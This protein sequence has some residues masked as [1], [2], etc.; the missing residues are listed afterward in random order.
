MSATAASPEIIENARISTWFRVGGSADRFARPRGLDEL[1]RCIE[2]DRDLRVVGD[3]ANLLVGDDGVGELVVALDAPELSQIEI[4]SLSGRVEVGAGAPLPKVISAT[5]KAG[6]GGLERIAGIPASIGGAIA[7]NAGGSFGAISDTLESVR[8]IDRNG[9]IRERRASE[10]NLDYRRADLHGEIVVSAVFQ[11][12]P[13]DAEALHDRLVEVMGYKKRTQPLS[14]RSAG[15]AFRNPVL[16]LDLEDIGQAGERV[17]AGLLIDRAGCKGLRVGGA[18][19]SSRHA[20]FITTDP[21]AKA[22]D[23]VGVMVEVAGR[24]NDYAGVR[25]RPEIVIWRRGD[26]AATKL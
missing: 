18:E 11:L 25:L 4:D 17:S 8:T 20:N 1:K 22:A 6:L 2:I 14:D 24:V 19:V 23:V 10:L 21:D 7:M 12:A 26:R 15:C 16:E 5:V 9:E 13:G 3:G